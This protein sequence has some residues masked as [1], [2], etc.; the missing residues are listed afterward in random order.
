MV[1]FGGIS[2]VSWRRVRNGGEAAIRKE[3]LEDYATIGST[4]RTRGAWL[5]A[6]S[7]LSVWSVWPV[8]SC[9]VE[10]NCCQGL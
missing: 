4:S 8:Q 7:R 1:S 6:I 5:A 2:A 10:S 9:S 3:C